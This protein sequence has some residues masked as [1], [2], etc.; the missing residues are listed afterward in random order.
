MWIE[1]IYYFLKPVMPWRLRL[2]LR[3]WR[4]NSRR[5]TYGDVWPI[6]Q[7]A[8]ATPPGWPGWPDGKRFALVLTHDVEGSKG[9][10]RIEQLMHLEQEQGFQSS[11]NL[12]PEGEYRVPE[13][14]RQTLDR[15]GFEVGIHG[16]E[17]DG[18]LYNSKARFAAKA[19][20]IREYLKEWNASG[21]RSPLMQHKLAWL[22]QLNVAYD[23]STFDT[24]PFE[25]EPDGTG[26][27]FPFWVP[28]S[29]GEGYVELPYTLSQDF[30]LFKVLCESNI[31][32]WKRKLDWIAEHGGMALLNTHP[33]YICFDGAKPA[34]DEYP[35]SH[36][37]ELLS[38]IREKYEGMFWLAQP[39]EVARFYCAKLPLPVRNSRK[40]ICMLTYSN[41]ATNNRVQ[42]YAEALAR[43]G[44][45][46]NVIALGRDDAPLGSDEINGVTIHRVQHERNERANWTS[47]WRQLRFL[48][49]SSVL[50]MRRH[51]RIRYDLIHVHNPP[52]FLVFAAS[53]P[54][55]AG[56]Q[57]IL[58]IDDIKEKSR[59]IGPLRA[60]EKISAAFV[61]HVI[62]AN[63][64]WYERLIAH[65]FPKEKCSVFPNHVDPDIL[66]RRRRT[67]S[68]GKFIV[69][70][71][72]GLQRHQGMDIAI[73]AL[74]R[75]RDKVP[76]AEFHLYGVA[77]G[78]AGQDDAASLA[79]GLG[80]NG[81]VEFH[82]GL[83]V[84]QIADVMANADLGV[85]PKHADSFGNE[86]YITQIMEF[87][88][89]GIPVVA[90]R[91][92]F[93]SF[94]FDESVVRFFAS[95]DDEAMAEAVLEV[96]ENKA[97]REGLIARGY[98]FVQSNSWDRR[99][100]AYFQLVD[101]LSTE[102]FGDSES[103]KGISRRLAGSTS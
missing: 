43:R 87:M 37:Q 13:S 3:R 51:Q 1:K 78:S 97:L 36:Y 32:I 33:D 60:V 50:L 34:R 74:A 59:D 73:K 91:A 95:G 53:Y 90:S 57:L 48:L 65:S 8:G 82:S 55:C 23:C 16:L 86:A 58:D 75:I 63:E 81:S 70:F 69:M 72:G 26:T 25:P 89:H 84:H 103:T 10:S 4:A 21:F 52:D 76:N 96:I 31:E 5:I 20:R 35:V 80:L 64:V 17:H 101:S 6:D 54:K 15:A 29:N 14:L 2:A 12:V 92:T 39:R 7:K 77:S 88:S 83:S 45:Q 40:K 24:D 46:V 9:L 62:V 28:G 68:D 79:E 47:T 71:W 38:Y 44:D 98:E 102:A 99:R 85:V 42:R 67:R 93:N 56:A 11:F 22:H 18:K 41:Y 100:Q 30:T 49:V 19:S 61:D 94:H 27:I 66:C